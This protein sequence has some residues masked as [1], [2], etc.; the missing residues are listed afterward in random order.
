MYNTIMY[1]NK[2]FDT[3]KSIKIELLLYILNFYMLKL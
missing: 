3:V 1:F 2:L